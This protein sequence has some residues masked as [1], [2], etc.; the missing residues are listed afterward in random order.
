MLAYIK[1]LSPDEV[2]QR[3]TKRCYLLDPL[4]IIHCGTNKYITSN[5]IFDSN[6]PVQKIN[7]LLL[8]QFNSMIVYM[9]LM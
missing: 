8:D 7:L 2:L 4:L 1:F 9:F 3:R 5:I 6:F